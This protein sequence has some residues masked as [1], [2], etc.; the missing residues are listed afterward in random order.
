MLLMQELARVMTAVDVYVVPV[1]YSVYTPNPAATLNT[2]VTNLT[3]QPCVQ[4][5]H[6]FDE[7]GHPTA[8]AFIGRVFGEAPMLALARAYQESTDWHRRHPTL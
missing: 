6:G 2:N 7:K 3:G 1:D 5:P 4:V 8:L